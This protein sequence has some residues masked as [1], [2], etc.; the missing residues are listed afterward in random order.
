MVEYLD[1]AGLT[2][3]K[4]LN[5]A[6]YASKDVATAEAAGLMLAE[7]KTELDDP[8]SSGGAC[9]TDE[10]FLAEVIQ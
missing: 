5:D 6:A 3:L 8:G 7:D 10:E 9:L 4:A 1:E 2:Q